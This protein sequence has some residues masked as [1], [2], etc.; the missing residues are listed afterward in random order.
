MK[1][2]E[3]RLDDIIL[4]WVKQCHVYHPPVITIFMWY[5]YINHSQSWAVPSGKLT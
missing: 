3:I 5:I 2:W 4:M 1:K